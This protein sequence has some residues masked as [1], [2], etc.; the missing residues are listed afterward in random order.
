MDNYIIDKIRRIAIGACGS[1]DYDYIQGVYEVQGCDEY[2][3]DNG[4]QYPVVVIGD[5]LLPILRDEWIGFGQLKEFHFHNG[6]KRIADNAFSDTAFEKAHME[7]PESL[8]EIGNE[9]FLKSKMKKVVIPRNVIHIGKNAFSPDMEVE[10]L[11]PYLIREE[12]NN[13]TS[14]TYHAGSVPLEF[15]I[16]NPIKKE[17]SAICFTG[18]DFDGFVFPDVV[19]IGGDDYL[20]T[21]IDSDF[22]DMWGNFVLPPH[23]RKIGNGIDT[24]YGVFCLP[25]TILYIGYSYIDSSGPLHLPKGLRFIANEMECSQLI[26]HSPYIDLEKKCVQDEYGN[27][28]CYWGQLY[29]EDEITREFDE[30]DYRDY[31]K[32][33]N[34][35]TF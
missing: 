5:G 10:C 18:K 12:G 24:H 31:W 32:L 34:S 21:A 35:S 3:T 30:F 33:L 28:L 29:Q 1:Y 7:L 9:A 19:T 4:H 2:I 15:R 22:G 27:I 23:L 6:I 11:S 14:K 16:T 20:V 8:L 25:E 26:N 17:V 13:F